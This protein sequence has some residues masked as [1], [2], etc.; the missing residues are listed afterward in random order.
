M[1]DSAFWLHASAHSVDLSAR[2]GWGMPLPPPLLFSHPAAPMW[3][4]AALQV[5]RPHW[6]MCTWAHT[7]SHSHMPPHVQSHKCS[8]AHTPSRVHAHSTHTHTSSAC[9]RSHAHTL[10]HSMLT[11]AYTYTHAPTC[12]R[13]E[14]THTLSCS[15]LT[16]AY[17]HTH[18]TF[19][20][21]HMLTHTPSPR[22][23]R[24]HTC[25][26]SHTPSVVSH[27]HVLTHT[28]TCLCSHV[29]T[30][31]PSPFTLTPLRHTYLFTHLRSPLPPRV[32][33]HKPHML[34]CILKFSHSHILGFMLIHDH[35][36][37]FTLSVRIH[38]A[39]KCSHSYTLT[40]TRLHTHSHLQ[41]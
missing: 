30:L 33:A 23:A 22:L 26:Y 12:S 3:G 4:C 7:C 25:L 17:P 11:R 40:L 15:T 32:H 16:H 14:L 6:L 20:R 13:S 27:S 34:T 9:S 29:L 28:P 39:L 36:D 18:P 19:S 37:S 10:S 5:P 41:V 38:D 21:S 31:T 1:I 35:S 8:H 24:A 2:G